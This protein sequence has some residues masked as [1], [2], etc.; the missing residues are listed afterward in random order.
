MNVGTHAFVRPPALRSLGKRLGAQWPR[1]MTGPCVTLLE[2]AKVVSQSGGTMSHLQQRCGSWLLV[3]VAKLPGKDD[4]EEERWLGLTAASVP[5]MA[6]QLHGSGP[7]GTC[8][9]MAERCGGALLCLRQPE[10]ER[11]GEGHG[12]D[13]PFW[14]SPRVPPLRPRPPACC[15]HQ[16]VH[17]NQGGPR[18]PQHSPRS[19]PT[20]TSHQPGA[21]GAPH[22][23]TLASREWGSRSPC[24]PTHT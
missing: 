4:W 11:E 9:I 13:A 2:T 21:L 20:S 6:G 15:C 23:Q 18:G 16:A 3:P 24:M 7:Q 5:S 1:P 22:I 14:G 17:S 12:E 8:S 19:H 10:A